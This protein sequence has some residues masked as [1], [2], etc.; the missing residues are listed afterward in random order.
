MNKIVVMIMFSLL[1]YSCV[2]KHNSDAQKATVTKEISKPTS[3]VIG[4]TV[5]INL[6]KSKIHWKG[7]KMHGIGKHYGEIHMKSGYFIV[8]NQQLV[9][10]NFIVDMTTLHVTDI[11]E[12][13]T[14]PIK[15]L[16]NH[17]KS[18]DF[19]DIEKFPISQFQ[20]SNVKEIVSD[21]ILVTGNLT[22]KNSTKN[23]E[24]SAKYQNNSFTTRF[25][26]DR[27]Q[28]NIAYE[29]NLADKTLVDKDIELKIALVLK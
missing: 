19:F 29:G 12:H 18:P 11:P 6:A 9:S 4:D 22:L 28:W 20:I 3:D 25:T 23:I 7:T 10:G 13:E 27:F 2:G 14:I 24:F 8:E 5:Q 17:L 21:S 1:L 15:N 16:N 26:F